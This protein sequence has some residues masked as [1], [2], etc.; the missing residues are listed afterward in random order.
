MKCQATRDPQST[1]GLSVSEPVVEP[2]P[3][4][5]RVSNQL[6]VDVTCPGGYSLEVHS[7]G[8]IATRLLG[9]LLSTCVLG[10]LLMILLYLT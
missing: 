2:L 4:A 8:P 7:V 6:G 10:S 1:E 3:S 9:L 5:K